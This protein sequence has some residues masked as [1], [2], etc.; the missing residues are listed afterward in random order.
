MGLR[1]ASVYLFSRSKLVIKAV[2][3]GL[4]DACGVMFMHVCEYSCIICT[5]SPRRASD[6]YSYSKF[7]QKYDQD[8]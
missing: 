2:L 1:L 4:A 5:T 7:P 3:D 6:N 8:L